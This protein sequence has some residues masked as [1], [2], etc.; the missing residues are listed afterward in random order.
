MIGLVTR[1]ECWKLTW[2]GRVA[3]VVVLVAVCA[4]AVIEVHPF[5]AVTDRVSARLLIIEGWAQAFAMEQAAAEFRSGGYERMVLIR[6]VLGIDDQY[7]SGRYSGNYLAAL[8]VRHGV[9]KNQLTTLFPNVADSDRTYH[10]ALAVKQ[11]LAEQGF[12]MKS[13]NVATL[14]PH[15]RRSRLLYQ[16]AF[17]KSW[18]VGI[19]ALRNP[20]YDPLHWW[21]T[22][23][24]V[25][26][27]IGESV[28]YLYARFL[29][30]QIPK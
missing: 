18:D 20:E 29:F 11:W 24:G 15:A 12:S 30:Y 10:S 1:R 26:A 4:S 2:R 21:R 25:R 8:L 9:P 28:A 23:E 7:Q 16:K 14:G 19:I 6:P 27:V 22:S 3:L 5:L 17:G 13:I